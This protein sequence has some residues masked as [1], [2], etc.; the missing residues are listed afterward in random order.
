MS[1]AAEAEEEKQFMRIAETELVCENLLASFTPMVARIA[2]NQDNRFGDPIV[3]DASVMALS[4]Y[5]CV[6][7]VM[8][9]E[10]LPLLFTVI[11]KEPLVSVRAT[12]MVALGD[13]AFRVPNSVEPW[14]EHIYARLADESPVVKHNTLMVL[15]HLVLNDMVKVKGQVSNIVLCLED[16]DPRIA[17][18]AKMFFQELSKR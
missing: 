17:D 1:A 12:A 4:K 10:Y 18:L 5:M 8:C 15:T 11:T 16:P 6:S 9:E 14:T 2:A 13:L 3:R 7:S